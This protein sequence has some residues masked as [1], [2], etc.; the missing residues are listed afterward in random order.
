M[1]KKSKASIK[2]NK[3]K[4]RAAVKCKNEVL[5][6]ELAFQK[7]QFELQFHIFEACSVEACSVEACS[8][9][10]CSVE[11]CSF[12]ACSFAILQLAVLQLAVLQLAVLQ[13]EN[14]KILELENFGACKF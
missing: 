13:L 14:L 5:D 9:E 3:R 12:A 7:L 4:K 10:A 2:K 11:A 8:V 1:I 6:F